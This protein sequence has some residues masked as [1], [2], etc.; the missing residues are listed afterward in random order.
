MIKTS[1]ELETKSSALFSE[2]LGDNLSKVDDLDDYKKVNKAKFDEVSSLTDQKIKA[3]TDAADK[4]EQASKLKLNEKFKEYLGV[5]VQEFRKRIEADKLVSPI[6]KLFVD[7]K[8]VD[9]W[10]KGI[11]EYNTKTA[12]IVKEADDLGKKADQIVKDNPTVIK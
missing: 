10:N 12:A 7:A 3:T 11:R 5:K 2:L 8:E 4:F 9:T 6:I 1:N